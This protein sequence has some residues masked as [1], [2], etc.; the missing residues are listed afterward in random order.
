MCQCRCV[1][2]DVLDCCSEGATLMVD[3]K[4]LRSSR[5]GPGRL[6]RWAAVVAGSAVLCAGLGSPAAHATTR[7]HRRREHSAIMTQRFARPVTRPGDVDA[8]PR[9][10]H[11]VRELQYRLR[12]AGDYHGRLDGRYGRAVTRAVA[13]FQARAHLQSASQ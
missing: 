12:S 7:D 10:F 4:D 2:R 3:D 6:L 5:G 9:R 11:H 8:S 1:L 13:R